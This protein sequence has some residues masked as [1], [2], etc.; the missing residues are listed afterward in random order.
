MFV[1]VEYAVTTVL[2]SVGALLTVIGTLKGSGVKVVFAV[3]GVTTS[4]G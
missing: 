1:I 4:T 2:S 3:I